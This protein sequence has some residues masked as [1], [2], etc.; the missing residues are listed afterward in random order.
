[1]I[2]QRAFDVINH[3][4]LLKKLN[5]YGIRGLTND[6]FRSYL[7]DRE[8]FV[9][10]TGVNSNRV[11]MTIG[12]PQ[13]SILGPLLY[14]L[15]VNDINNSCDGAILSFADDTTLFTSH[16]DIGELYRNANHYIKGLYDW[17]CSNRLSLNPVKTKYIVLRPRHM[18]H[19]LSEYSIQIGN[20]VLSRIGNDCTEKST[21]FLGMHLDENLTW[22]L[23]INETNKKVSKTLFSI[24]QLKNTLPV[25]SL[26]TLYFAL[27][28]SHLTY[29]ILAWGN[30][31]KGIIKQTNILQKRAIRI[32]NKAAFN[33]HTDSKFKK[34][35]ILKLNDLFEYQSLLFMHD[36]ICGKLP[37]SFHGNYPMNRDIQQ[38]HQTRQSGLLYVPRYA[39]KYAQ[40]SPTIKC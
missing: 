14:L 20:T 29:G 16:S 27:V 18:K 2:C 31:D 24:K 38:T 40:R 5:N 28:H 3:D 7:S 11:P 4:I 9:D 34:L 6:W 35:E 12:V 17:F 25:E 19:N 21:K 39:S 37:I 26:R 36:Y 8:H 1:M 13:G 15:Y 22:K 32:I 30:T 10:I 33:S 23:H